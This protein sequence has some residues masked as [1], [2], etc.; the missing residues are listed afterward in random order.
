M[1]GRIIETGLRTLCES[2]A[3]GQPVRHIP[4]E[5]GIYLS[6][7]YLHPKDE[8]DAAEHPWGVVLHHFKSSDADHELHNHP[9]DW[10]VALILTGGYREERR[11][12]A[13]GRAFPRD[14]ELPDAL[15]K[16]LEELR[17][18]VRRKTYRP[19]SVNLIWANTFHRVDLLDE[20]AGCWTLFIHGK[21]IQNWGFWNRYTDTFMPWR[22]FVSRREQIR[23]LTETE[24]EQERSAAV[25]EL[26][27]NGVHT[28]INHPVED[29]AFEKELQ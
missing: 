24:V 18:V 7:H 19:G 4:K 6:R 12:F 25:R 13:R 22:K 3:A 5:E 27:G 1:I 10:G 15:R 16:A 2:L 9:W 20:K 17:Y 23:P 11:W 21:R 28:Y 29:A 26:E 8:D 14:M